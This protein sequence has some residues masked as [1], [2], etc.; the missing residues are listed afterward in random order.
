MLGSVTPRC[1]N[2]ARRPDDDRTAVVSAL[3]NEA[4]RV[5]GDA[6]DESH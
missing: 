2:S 4:K 1:T 5:D 3:R 6:A